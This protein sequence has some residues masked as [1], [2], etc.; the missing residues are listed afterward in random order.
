M[1]NFKRL[2]ESELEA[3]IAVWHSEIPVR[4]SDL[5]AE[6]TER[7]GWNKSTIFTLLLRL[8]EK[9]YLS[10]SKEGKNNYYTPLVGEEEYRAQESRSILN[11]FYSGSVRNFVAAFCNENELSE[12][13]LDQLRALVEEQS[14]R[15]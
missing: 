7:R 12:E 11:R 15:R 5:A 9:G 14:E 13:E 8:V 1:K 6:L 4:G 3:M 2:P 10:C